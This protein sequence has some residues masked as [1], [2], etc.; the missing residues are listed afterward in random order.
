MNDA[1]GGIP[2][3]EVLQESV[4]RCVVPLE[5]IVIKI[6]KLREKEKKRKEKKRKE[7]KRKEKKRKEKKR[8][9]K[10]RKEKKRREEKRRQEKRRG[11]ERRGEERRGE[12]RRGEERRE[13]KRKETKR[14][15]SIPCCSRWPS[16]C[17]CP[18]APGSYG[19]SPRH[20]CRT[21]E[22]YASGPGAAWGQ[23][24]LARYKSSNKI[25]KEKA[26][27]RYSATSLKGKSG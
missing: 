2:G 24:K 12:E 8:K 18:C 1:L 21:R 7:K 13:E 11:E 10:K 15:E 4:H 27:N 14:N 19:T 26:K 5:Y 25:Q 16:S 22:T 20:S 23:V 17:A 9:E 3:L 6:R